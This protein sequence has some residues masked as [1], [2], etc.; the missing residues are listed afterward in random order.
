M[1]LIQI[2]QCFCDR[3]RLRILNLLTRSALCVCH[4]QGILGEHQ[5]KVSKHLAYLRRKRMVT[6]AREQNWI[7]YSLPK[8]APNEL[9]K[10]LRC[11]QDCVQTDAIFKRDLRKLATLQ[12]T[13]CE[14]VCLFGQNTNRG[15]RNAKAK[16]S[17]H[18][19][20]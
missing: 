8:R 18:L 2:Y 9:Q 6:T 5:V 11:L 13:C 1:D 10:N 20:A 3:T 12:K 14:P 4:F 16:S 15:K 19:R 17:I 7:I